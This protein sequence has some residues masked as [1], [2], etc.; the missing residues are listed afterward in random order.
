M[1]TQLVNVVMLAQS[2]GKMTHNDISA[3][4]VMVKFDRHGDGNMVDVKTVDVKLID[5]GCATTNIEM[6]DKVPSEHELFTV[7]RRV[8]SKLQ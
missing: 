8:E 6:K 7:S 4:N 5:F 3:S 1:I 2:Q